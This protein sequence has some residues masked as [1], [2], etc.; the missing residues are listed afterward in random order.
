MRGP[1]CQAG[2]GAGT[3]R[4]HGDSRKKLCCINPLYRSRLS[5]AS[6]A[7]FR[8]LPWGGGVKVWRPKSP[9]RSVLCVHKTVK[10]EGGGL[11]VTKA[12]HETKGSRSGCAG[13]LGRR[14]T[15]WD[16]DRGRKPPPAPRPRGSVNVAALLLYA[17]VASCHPAADHSGPAFPRLATRRT[18]VAG[19]G[20]WNGCRD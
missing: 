12:P 9:D 1:E 16:K 7:S 11:T 5:F 15:P 8:C 18:F 20:G 2:T 10:F 6:S 14:R 13:S 17:V 19:P 4:G 3:E